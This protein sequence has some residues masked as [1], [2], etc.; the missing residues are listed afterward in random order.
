R[1]S[2]CMVEQP[3][4]SAPG[5][6]A[7]L[8]LLVSEGRSAGASGGAAKAVY[9]LVVGAAQGGPAPR[10]VDCPPLVREVTEDTTLDRAPSAQSV[11][12]AGTEPKRAGGDRV[13]VDNRRIIRLNAQGS[14]CYDR[15]LVRGWVVHSEIGESAINDGRHAMTTADAGAD[16]EW[17]AL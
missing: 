4:G 1:I 7:R 2:I 9:T 11:S 14:G 16:Q 17:G 13:G 15:F 12:T 6:A 10:E 5:S 3:P 8:V